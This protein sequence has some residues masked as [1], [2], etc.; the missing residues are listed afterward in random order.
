ME[1]P[2]LLEIRQHGNQLFRLQVYYVVLTRG[3]MQQSVNLHWHAETEFVLVRT[4]TVR[5]QVGADWYNVKAGT[6]VMVNSEELHSMVAPDDEP[7]ECDAIVFHLDML[8]SAGYDSIQHQFISPLLE[9]RVRF[10]RLIQPGTPWS[11]A[12]LEQLGR[13]C[14]LRYEERPAFEMRIKASLYSVLSELYEH[15]TLEGQGGFSRFQEERLSRL[16][17]VLT[18]IDQNLNQRLHL[19]DLASVAHM[20]KGH[21][22]RFFRELT[23]QKPMHYIND[24]RIQMATNLLRDPNRSITSIA[25]DLGFQDISY[26]IRV[27]KSFTKCTP[28]KYRRLLTT[29]AEPQAAKPSSV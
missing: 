24:R 13:L 15:E 1:S 18:Y 27:F 12:I 5:I 21:F 3:P 2:D 16:K 19:G 22:C 11:D 6:A 17:D 7:S 14:S 9:K 29:C 25:L 10:P 28:L 8:N 4:G 26:F 20:S 23:Q